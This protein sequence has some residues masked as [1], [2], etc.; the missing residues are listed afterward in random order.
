MF[1][2]LLLVFVCVFALSVGIFI[3]SGI[4]PVLSA[5]EVG[6]IMAFSITISVSC[7]MR[8]A[9]LSS[10]FREFFW[11]TSIKS[12]VSSSQKHIPLQTDRWYADL[13]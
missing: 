6:G 8:L 13:S 9:S 5:I 7:V 12:H 3:V 10:L 2:C 4:H 11:S 1:V